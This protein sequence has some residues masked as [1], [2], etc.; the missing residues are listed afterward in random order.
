MYLEEYGTLET[1]LLLTQHNNFDI[2][3]DVYNEY[4]DRL[5]D[6]R[7]LPIMQIE[8]SKDY[9]K[10]MEDNGFREH[11]EHEDA[12]IDVKTREDI[13]VLLRDGTR[14]DENYMNYNNFSGMLCN[15]GFTVFANGDIYY[16]FRDRQPIQNLDDDIKKISK[17]HV[18]NSSYCN[19]E[20]EFQKCSISWFAKN[21][22][23]EI[24]RF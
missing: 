15:S 24:S 19:C 23:G 5:H 1:V 13:Q 18:C 6:I 4:K 2:V 22:K 9:E 16:C 12:M 11:S 14:D 17:W 3:K 20:F 8:G 7:I 10:F 21:K